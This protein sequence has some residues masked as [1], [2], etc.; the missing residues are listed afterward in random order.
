MQGFIP[1]DIPTKPYIKAYVISKL[2]AQP[3][4]S[5]SGDTIGHKLY[6]LLQ[7]KTNE[8]AARYK[9]SMYSATLRIYIP[10]NTF[11]KRGSN[12]NETNLKNFNLFI[13]R[14]IKHRFYQLMEDAHEHTPSFETNLPMIRR[15][16]GIDLEAWSD[17]SMKKDYYRKRLRT[18]QQL[19]YN[20]KNKIG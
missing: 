15:K 11:R 3:R 6:D 7:H 12:L 5:T 10:I 20:K 1:V 9:N 16:L 14:E 19:L 4:M 13:E 2:S 18:N 8:R 17:D